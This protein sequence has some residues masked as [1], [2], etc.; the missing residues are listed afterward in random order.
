MPAAP[1]ATPRKIL[2]PPMTMPISQP[3][4]D[5]CATS[6]TIDS[7]VW[8]LMPKGSSPIRASPESLRR[9]LLYLGVTFRASMRFAGLGHDFGSEVGRF[10]LDALAHH[11]ERVGVH[12]GFPRAEHLLYR[13]LVVLDKGLAEQRF[14]AEELVERTLDHLGDD[15]GRLARLLGARLL[16]APLVRD[17]I[18]R[19]LGL[20]QIGGLGKGDVHGEVFAHLFRSLVIDQHADLRAV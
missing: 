16:D 17:D 18:L 10:L 20:G 11:E 4:R 8:R 7:M 5:T 12:L 2:P 13:L 1:G 14:L 9:I 3:R 15:F 19:D 6:A